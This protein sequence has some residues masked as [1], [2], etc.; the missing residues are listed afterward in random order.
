MRADAAR[1]RECI[2]EAAR[3][4]FA[5]QGTNA[6]LEEIARRAGVGIATLYRRFP[7]RADLVTAAFEPKL[8]Q[9]AEAA[10]AAT[11]EPDPWR[12]FC[13]YVRCVCAMQAA[14][15]GFADV[16]TL[17]FP[18]TR[19]LAQ[20]LHEASAGVSGV[21]AAA[22]AAGKLRGDF[23]HQDLAIVLMANAGVVNALGRRAP[24]ASERF[25]AY[26]LDAFAAPAGS[27]LPPPIDPLRIARALRSGRR[28]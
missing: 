9:Y 12:G 21:I 13:R 19:Q 20:R 14:D 3:A 1:N 17:T 16:L 23:V 11:S 15:A 7:C 18:P 28:R 24:A 27:P 5:E 6:P 4:T 2:L 26:L 8:A 25:V 10:R 22:Q